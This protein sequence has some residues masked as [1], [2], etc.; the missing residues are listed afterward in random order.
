MAQ[1]APKE[2]ALLGME[3]FREGPTLLRTPIEVGEMEDHFEVGD[4]SKVGHLNLHTTRNSLDKVSLP[5]EPIYEEDVVNITAQRERD[6]R[7]RN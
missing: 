2:R 1:S 4:T 5:P 7:I 3:P 6:R